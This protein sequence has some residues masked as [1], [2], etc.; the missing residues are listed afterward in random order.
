MT[1][2][3]TLALTLTLT[4][5]PTLTLTLTRLVLRDAW[6]NRCSAPE[7]LGGMGGGAGGAHDGGA[8]R[9]PPIRV[10]LVPLAGSSAEQRL[11]GACLEAACRV[12]DPEE[13]VEVP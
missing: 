4:L 13:G 10:A 3:L 5:T 2:T 8:A 6:G 7:A 9:A 12:E 11:S 1:L